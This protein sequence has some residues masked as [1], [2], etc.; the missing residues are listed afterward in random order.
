MLLDAIAAAILAGLML[1]PL[2]NVVVGGVAGA[3][4]FGPLGCFIGVMLA[5]VIMGIET[6]IA[7][8]L[9]WRDL[10]CP[11]LEHVGVVEERMQDTPADE[12][13]SNCS[14]PSTTVA[15]ISDR[16][17][18]TG[19]PSQRRTSRRLRDRHARAL[20]TDAMQQK[21]RGLRR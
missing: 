11:A 18:M 4:L 15:A 3:G 2:V 10:H 16:A 19:S 9:G 5:F 6:W 20:H 1:I 12:I 14:S 8:R 13:Y 21:R 7:D 17:P